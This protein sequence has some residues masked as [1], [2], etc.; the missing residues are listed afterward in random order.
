VEALREHGYI[1]GHN[2]MIHY[3]SADYQVPDGR[4]D[5]LSR[6]AAELVRLNVDVIVADTNAATAAAMKA[7]TTIP[8]VF[9]HGDPVR[10]GVVPSLAN[11]GKN[12]TGLSGVSHQLA[13]KRLEVLKEVFPR[14]SRVG[15][16]FNGEAAHHRRE[17]AEMQSVAGALGIELQ[18]LEF[19]YSE[20]SFERIFQEAINQRASAVLTLQGPIVNFHRK[21]IVD[22]AARYRLPAMYPTL[23]FTNAGGLM[24]YGLNS[25]HQYRR[26]A[27]FV[28]RILKGTKPSDLPVEQ[29]T[30]FELAINLNTA[31]AL[32]IKIPPKV[33]MWADRVINDADGMRDTTVATSYPAAAPRSPKLP[34]I[35]FLSPGNAKRGPDAFRQGLRALGYVEGQNIIVE[36]RSAEENEALLPVLAAELVRMDVDVIVA[37]SVLSARAAKRLTSTIPIIVMG[38]GDP[39]GMR[40]VKSLGQPGGNVTGMSTMAPE[41]GGK[42]LELLRE[43]IPALTGVAVLSY[44]PNGNPFRETSIKQIAG[45]AGPLGVQIQIFNLKT[46]DEI[47]EALSSMTRARI[48]ALMVLTQS[49]FSWKGNRARIVE[50]VAKGRLPTMYPESRYVEAGGLVSYGP[51]RFAD[52]RRAAYFVDKIL[53][54]A[55]P[56]DLPVEQPSKFELIINLKTAKTLGLTIPPKVLTWADRVIK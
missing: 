4:E 25:A 52:Q 12:V 21:R 33:L 22:L 53:R 2:V 24:S 46:S 17:F 20:Q 5:R 23:P 49:I 43:M 30:K 44:V 54:G 38:M 10:S 3:R 7:T 56:A 55:K 15:I 48:R 11:P 9:F 34:R 6:I 27:Y 1:E 19:R 39:V 31:A 8:I 40:L 37:G 51:D 50:S 26:A 29:P 16:L 13:G 14:I 35:G 45:I 32:G 28:Y 18:A 47:E 41:L 36:Y 42:R